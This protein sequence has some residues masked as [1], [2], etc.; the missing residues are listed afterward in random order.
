M[1]GMNSFIIALI[2]LAALATGFVLVR[3]LMTLAQGKD[4]TGA[5]SNKYMSL[6]VAFQLLTI[7]LV[8]VLL[9]AGGRGLGG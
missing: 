3:G 6:R 9:I 8:V 5:Q 7:L 2:V 1:S 4:V